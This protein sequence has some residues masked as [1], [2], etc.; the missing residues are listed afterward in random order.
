MLYNRF[1][2]K[3]G[4]IQLN[5]QEQQMFENLQ[6]TIK[7]QAKQ[8]D[9]LLKLNAQQ[10]E[11]IKMLLQKIDELTCGQKDS[12]NSSKPP[13]SDGYMKKPAPKSLRQSSGK[14]QGGQPGHKGSGMKI[15]RLP[16]E[17]IQHYPPACVSCPRRGE[18]QARL[19][20]KRYEY[21]IVVHSKL[22]EHQQMECCCPM[23]NQAVLQGKF[24]EHIKATK[25]YGLNIAA[26]ASA[27]ST[28]GMVGIDR[29]HQLLQSV[30][31]VPIST[32]TIRNML[33]RLT[34][35]TKEA[36]AAIKEHVQKLPCL[37][38]DE[39]GLRVAGSLHWLHC[40]CDEKWSFFALQKK[41]GAE[42]IDAIG[43][44]PGYEKLVV[45]DCWAP[46]EKYQKSSH[47]LCCAHILRELVYMDE[48]LGQAWARDM[49]CLLQEILHQRHTLEAGGNTAFTGEELAAYSSRYD[50]I[51]Q[52][53]IA[54]NPLPAQ[55]SG[56]RG[57][58]KRGKIRALL[59]RLQG[60]KDQILRFAWDWIVPFSN[61]EA[62]R[63]I[64]FSKV[65]QKVSGCFRTLSGAEDY[66]SIMSFISTASKHSVSYFDAVKAALNG[67]ALQLVGQ[68]A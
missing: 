31:Q 18:C 50:A 30:F 14:K 44:L 27:L 8:L 24:P 68:W 35:A 16:D 48:Q 9:S 22:V 45:H 5:A 34:D 25:Q 39:T 43:I 57:R 19:A 6:R 41:R 55:E 12:H 1:S 3:N 58:P 60:K 65:K 20:E 23:Q 13:S 17:T 11:K 66:A 49:K 4:V 26:F 29:I 53:G 7:L 10:A 40:A 15:E 54:G 51:V 63:S 62:E 59:D 28:V 64:R 37:H 67:D 21:D 46:Y 33:D 36:V 32:G 42:A 2:K 47:A 61:N 56:K 38:L 52:V